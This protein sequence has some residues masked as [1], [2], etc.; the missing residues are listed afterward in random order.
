[1]KLIALYSTVQ[2]SGK[3]TVARLIC[4]HRNAFILPFAQPVKKA[5]VQF[6]QAFGIG[7]QDAAGYVYIDKES[8][9]PGMPEGVTARFVQQRLATDF[10]RKMIDPDAWVKAW[11][12]QLCD[13]S[14]YAD[15]REDQIIVV[16]D[17]RFMGEAISVMKRDGQLWRIVNPSAIRADERRRRYKGFLGKLFHLKKGKHASEGNLDDLEFDVTI[18]N[19]GTVEQL[20]AKVLDALKSIR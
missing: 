16:D 7:I 12:R 4:K 10:V 8:Q 20:E 6:L 18:V 3:S 17:M 2:G 9:L 15:R 19:D 14:F 1:M 13:P 11:E 5:T